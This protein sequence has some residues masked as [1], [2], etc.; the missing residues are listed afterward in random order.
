[1]R[2]G[3]TRDLCLGIE[4]VLASGEVLDLM[5]SL[6]KDNT[7]LNLR[8]LFVGS[9]GILGV[10]T[11]AVL[12]LHPRPK[13]YAT[14]MVAAASLEDGLKILNGL[15]DE[16]GGMVEAFEYMPRFYIEQHRSSR[17]WHRFGGD[18]QG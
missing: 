4:V 11:A 3:N 1:M 6:H 18:I 15:Q 10:I 8:N 13:V 2:Y 12:K 17:R 5:T 7:G 14:A 9:E 16:S